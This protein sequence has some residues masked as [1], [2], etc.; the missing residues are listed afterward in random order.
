MAFI[1]YSNSGQTYNINSE[2]GQNFINDA[3]AGTSMI[4]GDGTKWLKNSDG[5]TSITNANGLTYNVGAALG[6][7]QNAL[8]QITH[9]SDKASARSLEYA[10]QNQEWSANQAAIANQFNASEAAKN[11]DW[12][13]YMSNTAHQ[14]EIAD[15]KAAGLNPVLSA[16]GGNGA[17]VGSGAAA[18]AN[19]P[20][21]AV[22]Q[23][24][25][26]A[27]SALVSILGSMLS[28]QTQLTNSALSARTQESV[29]DKYTAMEHLV[30]LISANASMS[31]ARTAAGASMYNARTAAEAS[32]F[33]S[34]N[35]L[36]GSMFG[37]VVGWEQ[38]KYNAFT[39]RLISGEDRESRE[40]MAKAERDL[41]L[42]LAELGVS[43]DVISSLIGVIG[44]IGSG[45]LRGHNTY[46]FGR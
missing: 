3:P 43:K 37:D 6:S 31:N 46:N 28:A 1:G 26:S 18:S 21:G 9:L 42:D 11:R 23:A 10:Q 35:S 7:M 38:T 44:S 4:G 41:A 29:A 2:R 40:A 17:S 5:S 36:L 45:A 39:N 30:S 27:N 33:S 13:E 22:G 25:T 8:D 32:R 14:R 20:S 24:D 16:M 12:Q 19:L 15:L 34:L